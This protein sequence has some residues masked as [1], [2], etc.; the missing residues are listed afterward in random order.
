MLRACYAAHHDCST[1]GSPSTQVALPPGVPRFA[2]PA[3]FLT[4]TSKPPPT[5][6]A[7]AWHPCWARSRLAPGTCAASCAP[8]PSSP[9]CPVSELTCWAAL[10]GCHASRVSSLVRLVWWPLASPARCSRVDLS[11]SALLPLLS[12]VHLGRG[13]SPAG[14]ISS[15]DRHTT[16][17]HQLPQGHTQA[18]AP[19]PSSSQAREQRT[20]FPGPRALCARDLCHTRLHALLTSS[21]HATDPRRADQAGVQPD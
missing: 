13:P 11:A 4:T 18:P 15:L 3:A 6:R 1:H 14:L 8:A 12:C 20:P 17:F 7:P 10:L 2:T 5:H 16:Q 21:P 9:G 19:A